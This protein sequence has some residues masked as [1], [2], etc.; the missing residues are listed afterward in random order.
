MT[1]EEKVKAMRERDKGYDGVFF[2]GVRT[3]GIVCLPSC[4]GQPLEKNVDFY[5]TLD[6]AVKTGLRYC[7]R[8][9][10]QELK[11]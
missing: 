11:K 2:V 3:T 1:R 7:K 6:E 4:P 8:C 9:K 10:P 5:D